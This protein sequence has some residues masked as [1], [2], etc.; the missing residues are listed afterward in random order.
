MITINNKKFET[1]RDDELIT[2]L[3]SINHLKEIG[4]NE[5]IWT[6]KSVLDHLKSFKILQRRFNNPL[7][8]LY[9]SIV[10]EKFFS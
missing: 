3:L 6:E 7:W 10:G 9:Y 2:Y 1:T 5:F 8:N 4:K